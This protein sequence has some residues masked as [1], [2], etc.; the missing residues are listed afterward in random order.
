M[1]VVVGRRVIAPARV[2]FGMRCMPAA[3]ASFMLAAA[4]MLPRNLNILG[5]APY[6]RRVTPHCTATLLRHSGTLAHLTAL[7]LGSRGLQSC[8]S[9]LSASSTAGSRVNSSPRPT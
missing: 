7:L 6:L 5:T 1:W 3:R 4:R 2:T 9:T 8:D